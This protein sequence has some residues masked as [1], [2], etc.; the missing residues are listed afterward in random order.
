MLLLFILLFFT[1]FLYHKHKNLTGKLPLLIY[2]VPVIIFIFFLFD[3]LL[4]NTEYFISDEIS[5]LKQNYEDINDYKNRFVWYFINYIETDYDFFPNISLKLLNI[6]FL[7]FFI[8]IL[9]LIFDKKKS[10]FY[11]V[12]LL[13]YLSLLATKNFRDILILLIMSLSIYMFY[14]L[15][16]TKKIL[17][18]IPFVLL[19][20]LRGFILWYLLFLFFTVFLYKN[21]KKLRKNNFIIKTRIKRIKKVKLYSTVFVL[22][23]LIISLFLIFPKIQKKTKSYLV[24]ITFYTGEGYKTKIEEAKGIQTGNKITDYLVGGIRY[25]FTPIPTSIFG[26]FIKGG[27]I[28]GL[29]DDLIRTINQTIYYFLLLY[30]LYNFKYIPQLRKKMNTLQKVFLLS[31]LLFLPIYTYY[32]FGMGHQRIKIPFQIAVFIIFVYIKRIKINRKI[33]KTRIR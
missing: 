29:T 2:I 25:A 4:G 7:F 20:Y 11:I 10:I 1:Y 31:L 6:P 27:S 21:L 30:I 9:W 18:L 5:Y 28:S 13:P 32:R 26:R 12:I 8:Y 15:K 22:I 16:K 19:L 24:A 3:V 17:V 33:E 14:S 23:I